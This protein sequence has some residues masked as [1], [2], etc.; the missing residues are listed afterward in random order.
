[1]IL[2]ISIK[3][4]KAQAWSLDLVI[5]SVIFII[6]IIVLYVYAINYSSQVKDQL[7]EFFY[8]GQLASELILSEKDQGILFQGKI[9][10]MKLETFNSLSNQEKKNLLGITHNF[11]FTFKGLEIGG[12][13]T[14]YIGIQN[15]TSTENFI[16]ITRLSIYKDTPIK[17]LLY[18]WK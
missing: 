8:E 6:G 7:D 10:Q 2:S 15:T 3:N 16:Q 5:A 12:M 11:Y 13:E 17:F 14:D 18:I 4:K 1:M 9:N